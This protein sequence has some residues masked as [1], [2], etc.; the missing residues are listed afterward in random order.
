MERKRARYEQ[1]DF[2]FNPEKEVDKYYAEIDTAYRGL[3]AEVERFLAYEFPKRSYKRKTNSNRR[4][5]EKMRQRNEI[6]KRVMKEKN[7][8]LGPASKYVKEHGLWN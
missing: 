8:R 3:K 5:P 7:L 4:L 2:Y 6:V 1:I